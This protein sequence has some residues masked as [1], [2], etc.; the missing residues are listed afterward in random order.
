MVWTCHE[1]RA[2][3]FLVVVKEDMG[4]VGAKEMDI[5]DRIIWRY[6][7]ATSDVPILKYR[8]QWYRLVVS[9]L[10]NIADTW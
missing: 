7:V 1:E 8:Y 3:R 9:V 4:K 2:R 10:V 5:E 6:V